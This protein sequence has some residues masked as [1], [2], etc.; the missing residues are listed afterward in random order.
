MKPKVI[1]LMGSTALGALTEE[2]S[3]LENHGKVVPLRLLSGEPVSASGFAMVHPAFL[4]RNKE[5]D[6]GLALENLKELLE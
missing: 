5:F 1:V 3:I 2:R 6:I 4:I